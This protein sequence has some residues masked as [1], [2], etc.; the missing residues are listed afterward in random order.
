MLILR[1][2]VPLKIGVLVRLVKLD[3]SGYTGVNLPVIE[4]IFYPWEHA[5]LEKW[6]ISHQVSN[7]ESDS[8]SFLEPARESLEM[9]P[10]HMSIRVG[11]RLKIKVVLLTHLF[12]LRVWV[13]IL[14][15]DHAR[16]R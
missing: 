2:E 10:V 6:L 14:G 7:V 1:D 8:C 9:E 15:L 4:L 13:V 3:I 16:E 11:V 12:N 5:L